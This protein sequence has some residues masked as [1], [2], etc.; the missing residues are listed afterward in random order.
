MLVVYHSPWAKQVW[1]Q[2]T[3]KKHISHGKPFFFT[4]K[5]R[6]STW[7]FQWEIWRHEWHQ[8]ESNT[9]PSKSMFVSVFDRANQSIHPMDSNGLNCLPCLPPR[10]MSGA[11]SKDKTICCTCVAWNL[12]TQ[13]M[14]AKT[15]TRTRG[16]MSCLCRRLAWGKR[17]REFG[18]WSMMFFSQ[19]ASV[20]IKGNIMF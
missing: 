7:R 12:E 20:Y 4:N 15:S 9:N 13:D 2:K 8:Q 19:V 14:A 5:L 3:T 16:R 1:D 10:P 6:Q 18:P 17:T 11:D